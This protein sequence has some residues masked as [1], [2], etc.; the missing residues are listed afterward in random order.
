MWF[1]L[2]KIFYHQGHKVHTKFHKE[3]EILR[4]PV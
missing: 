2:K 1:K 4:D 3:Y